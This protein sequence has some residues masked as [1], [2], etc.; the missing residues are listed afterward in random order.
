MQTHISPHHLLCIIINFIHHFLYCTANLYNRLRINS[1]TK[2]WICKIARTGAIG[3]NNRQSRCHCLSSYQSKTFKKTWENQERSLI[4]KHF[5]FFARK[6]LIEKFYPLFQ[7]VFDDILRDNLRLV[8][9]SGYCQPITGDVFRYAMK[10]FK[11]AQSSFK[12][13]KPTEKQNIA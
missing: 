3:N 7:F 9:R 6:T 1:N 10:C 12:I 13:V 4:K 8:S 11:G 5:H 2:L